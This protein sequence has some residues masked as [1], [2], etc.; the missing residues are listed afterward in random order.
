MF[1][2]K[3]QST[4]IGHDLKMGIATVA[5]GNILQK[6]DILVACCLYVN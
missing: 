4:R 5:I 1:Y 6:Q 3:G 2:C